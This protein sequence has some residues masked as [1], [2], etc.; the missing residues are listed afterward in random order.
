MKV[1]TDVCHVS[2]TA[3]KLMKGQRSEVK[4]TARP[5]VFYGGG[6]HF[7]SVTSWQTCLT[8][9]YISVSVRHDF[10]LYLADFHL[11]RRRSVTDYR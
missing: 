2:G 4:V 11:A 8:Q 7:N 9:V 6:I 5:S 10:S 3:E 1:S